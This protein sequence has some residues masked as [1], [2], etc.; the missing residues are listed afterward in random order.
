MEESKQVLPWMTRWDVVPGVKSRKGGQASIKQV[1]DKESGRLGA[2]KE[3]HADPVDRK[4]RR[5]R[6]KQEVIGLIKAQ[7][8]GIPEFFDSNTERAGEDDALYLVQAWIDG[9]NLEQF[10]TN[11]LSIDEAIDRTLSLA[12]IIERCHANYVLHRDV[13]P[14]NIII[15]NG[16]KLYLVDFGI[17]WLPH[18]D[19]DDNHETKLGQELGNRF[20]RLPE[21]TAGQLR[22]DPRSDVTYVVGILFFLL[23]RQ[24]PRT[25]SFGADAAPPHKNL[26]DQFPPSTREDSRMVRLNS[27]FDVG[28]QVAP[29]QRF[30][31]IRKL[32]DSLEEVRNPRPSPQTI[33]VAQTLASYDAMMQEHEVAQRH[34]TLIAMREAAEAFERRIRELS[35]TRYLTPVMLA[36]SPRRQD[37]S[38]VMAGHFEH[39]TNQGK[40]SA[41]H[42]IMMVGNEVVCTSIVD[43]SR[44]DYYQGPVADITRLKEEV[45]LHIAPFF[46]T[47]LKSFINAANSRRSFMDILDYS[48]RQQDNTDK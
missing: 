15:D 48:E 7:G 25:L 42:T 34:A 31:S 37:N 27:I 9:K 46:A 26:R 41:S 19:R 24:Y 23:T 6:M 33:D 20:L 22:D 3:M 21:M 45:G 38:W 36:G 10:V 35:A 40:V 13:K 47:V 12:R 32:I 2:L 18:D 4:E 39:V 14:E 5:H 43:G 30:Q 28:F 8:D 17:A 44:N 1:V 11:C 16:G 29:N